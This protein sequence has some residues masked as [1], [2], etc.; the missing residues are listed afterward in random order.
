MFTRNIDPPLDAVAGIRKMVAPDFVMIESG[1]V[2]S[3]RTIWDSN[4]GAVIGFTAASESAV[5]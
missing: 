5:A 3:W 4:C 2:N 1:D